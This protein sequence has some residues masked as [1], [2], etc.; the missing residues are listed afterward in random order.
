MLAF[1]RGALTVV[2]NAGA[3]AVEL[4]AGDVV[5]ASG[6][7]EDRLLPADTAAWLVSG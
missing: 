6:E 5:V 4:P 2:L 7:L 3:D 1:T